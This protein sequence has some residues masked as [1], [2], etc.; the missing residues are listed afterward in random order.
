MSDSLLKNGL[1]TPGHSDR[2][3]NRILESSQITS[4]T[5]EKWGRIYTCVSENGVRGAKLGKINEL[6]T[7]SSSGGKME[8]AREFWKNWEKK[9]VCK[10]NREV[11]RVDVVPEKA[12]QSHLMS[13]AAK[14]AERDS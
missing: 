10:G 14:W 5:I 4:G 2:Q 11:G 13:G 6:K 1:T 8:S 12:G 9:L 3:R 7:D